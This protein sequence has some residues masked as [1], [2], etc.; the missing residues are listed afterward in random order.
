MNA[1][2][3][4]DSEDEDPLNKIDRMKKSQIEDLFHNDYEGFRMLII[5]TEAKWDY[6]EPPKGNVKQQV[7]KSLF[8]DRPKQMFVM[9]FD[10]ETETDYSVYLDVHCVMLFNW[11]DHGFRYNIEVEG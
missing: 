11:W 2:K 8:W 10:S 5:S 6:W 1:F 7:L 4:K 3:R 9:K